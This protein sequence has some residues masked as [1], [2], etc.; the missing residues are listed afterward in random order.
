MQFPYNNNMLCV[1]SSSDKWL[2]ALFSTTKMPNSDKGKSQN[3][4]VGG[5]KNK[6]RI[7]WIDVAKGISIIL[8][9]LGHTGFNGFFSDWLRSF[10][11]PLFFIV[12]GMVFN[13]SKYPNLLDFLKRRRTTILRPY[14]I[15]S[16]TVFVWLHMLN[17]TYSPL[18]SELYSGWISYALWFIPVL[19]LAQM[20]YYVIRK[21]APSK[22]WTLVG[23]IMSSVLG[24]M[25]MRYGFKFWFKLEVVFT[26]CLFYGIGNLIKNAFVHFFESAKTYLICII[27]VCSFMVS[28]VAS[29]LTEPKMDLCSNILGDVYFSYPAAIFGTLFMICF[30]KILCQSSSRVSQ[31]LVECFKY[32]GRNSYVILAYHQAIGLTLIT[33]FLPLG[34]PATISSICRHILLWVS[35]VCIIYLINN[36]MPWVLGKNKPD[37]KNQTMSRA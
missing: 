19:V 14:A 37:K 36:Y 16:L 26:A 13:Y 4:K 8:V 7:E 23:I 10:R 33:L 34:L 32:T 21:Y 6:G 28:L 9:V 1:Q 25:C 11:M 30:S 3:A 27:M 17:T 35:L 15:F 31:L 18:V 5:G 22:I 20:L 2:M 29:I 12:S 24:Y